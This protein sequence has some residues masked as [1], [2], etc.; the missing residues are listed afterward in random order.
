MKICFTDLLSKL[1]FI[2]N[3]EIVLDYRYFK[4]L[5]SE[6][7][8]AQII[9]YII[10]VMQ[11]VLVLQN[12]FTFHVNMSSVTL[13]HIEKYYPF[14][15][16]LSEIL[17]NTFPDRLDTCYIYNAPI[18]FSTLFRIVGVFIDKKTLSKIKLMND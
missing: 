14:I 8:Y 17:K 12:T 16:Q 4:F 13:L 5:A 10:S 9:N 2:M 18:V 7:N 1:C 6:E 3:N 11:K 15:K